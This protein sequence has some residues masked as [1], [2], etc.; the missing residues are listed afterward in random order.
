MGFYGFIMIFI[1]CGCGCCGW[2]WINFE[3]WGPSLSGF[4]HQHPWWVMFTRFGSQN[5]CLLSLFLLHWKSNLAELPHFMEKRIGLMSL[6]EHFNRT[7]PNLMVKTMVSCRFS[8]HQKMRTARRLAYAVAA[9]IC[10]I[11]VYAVH[12][13]LDQQALF[14]VTLGRTCL[15]IFFF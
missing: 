7:R 3:L 6:M 2:K 15:G 9:G 10:A 14:G 11:G 4:Q 12:G 5:N 13:I 1:G 8:I